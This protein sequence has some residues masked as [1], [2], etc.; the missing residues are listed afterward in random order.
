MLRG[1]SNEFIHRTGHN[2]GREVHGNGTHMDN[3]G[4][5]DD[6]KILTRTSNSIEPGIYLIGDFGV[7]SEIDVYIPEE[8]KVGVTGEPIQQ[9]VVA[10]LR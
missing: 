8:G 3:L 1:Y 4:T 9:E 7:R 10:I 6:R 5:H 2:I